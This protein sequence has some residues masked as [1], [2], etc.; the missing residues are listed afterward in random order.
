MWLR[1]RGSPWRPAAAVIATV[2]MMLA[3][4]MGPHFAGMRAQAVEPVQTTTISHTKITGDGNYFTFADNAWDPG[5]D[6]HTWSKAP[7]DSLPAEDIW[8][9]VRFFGSAIDVYAGK[10]RPMGKVKYYIDG[11]EKGTYS[12]Y[13]ASNINETKIAS[14][15]GLDE[16]EHVFKAV[17]TGE[18]DTNS[19]NALIDCA[20]VVVTHQPYVVTGVTLDTTS[21]TLGVGDSKRISYTVAPD[22]ATIDDMTYTSGDTSVATVGADG[23]VTAV[24]PGATAITVASTAA[25]IS[26]TVDVTVARM[27]PNLT[28]GIVD[29]DTQYTQKRFDEVKALTTNN[30]ALK[31]WKNDKVNSEISLAAVGTTVSN[32]TVTASDLTS[33]GGD[34]IAKSNVTATFIKSTRAYNGSYLGYGDPNREVPAA[35][36]TNRSESNDILYQSGPITVKANQVQNIWVSFAIPKDAKAG[37]Y[38]TTL[39]ATADGMETPLTFTYTIE[40]KAATLPDPAEYE[41]NF[42]VEL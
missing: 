28:G 19:T 9:T 2:S 20:K 33:Q 21:M 32:L 17:A 40:V 6:V 16:G 35:T 36:E 7:S 22:Y 14:F 24:A 4:V 38:T 37:T 25:G 34:V 13:N 42:D 30:R 8:Y 1:G 15:T 26:K 18:R 5:N 29:P 41:K 12:L 23:T 27:A 10:N 31:A 39:T 3:T 11:A